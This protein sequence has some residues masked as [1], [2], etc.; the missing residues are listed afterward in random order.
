MMFR[1]ILIFYQIAQIPSSDLLFCLHESHFVEYP[2]K[3]SQFSV[4][5]LQQPNQSINKFGVFKCVSAEVCSANYIAVS[6]N[7][8]TQV[9]YIKI[10]LEDWGQK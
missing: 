5:Y 6:Y 10:S 9:K 3:L 2:D 4:E 1:A 7:N 8:A